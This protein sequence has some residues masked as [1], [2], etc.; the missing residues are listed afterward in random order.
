M[1]K[2]LMTEF[3]QTQMGR[4]YYEVTVP[5]IAKQLKRI[6]DALEQDKKKEEDE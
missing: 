3:H 4:K 6:A 1:L 2:S 5:E